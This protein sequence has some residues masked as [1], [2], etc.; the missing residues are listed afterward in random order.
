MTTHALTERATLV[1]W[2]EHHAQT[3]PL[4][5]A[6]FFVATVRTTC[7]SATAPCP[8]ACAAAPPPC[9]SAGR[10]GPPH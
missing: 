8:T 10:P 1:D 5:E 6:L 7:G 4:A 2:I 3:R 9:S